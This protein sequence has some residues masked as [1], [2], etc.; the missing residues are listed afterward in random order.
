MTISITITIVYWASLPPRGGPAS[1][2]RASTRQVCV[3]VILPGTLTLCL[4]LASHLP[5]PKPFQPQAP[6]MTTPQKRLH[7]A[8]FVEQ[9]TPPK[10][11]AV[12]KRKR[13]T[14]GGGSP[15]R[16]GVACL[17]PVQGLR[18]LVI[19]LTTLR[20]S[21]SD[22][23]LLLRLVVRGCQIRCGVAR[24]VPV[25]ACCLSRCGP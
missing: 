9:A 6:T 3:N 13:G 21:N 15:L 2:R 7:S 8:A 23:N 1:T 18:R 10:V 22:W 5:L 11:D 4:P 19:L 20:D 12:K 14:P 25:A 17:R 24:G 16:A